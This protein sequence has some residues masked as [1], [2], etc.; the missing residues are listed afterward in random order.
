MADQQ[1]RLVFGDDGSA[2]ADLVWLWINNH[3]WPGWRISVV[4][5]RPPEGVVA[6]EG[7][8]RPHPWEPPV[9]R[10]LFEHADAAAV[11]YLTASA[12]P[13]V[14]L[15][16]LDASL[17]A[18]GPRGTGLL[19]AMNIGSTAEWLVHGHRPVVIVRSA[20]PTRRVLACVDGSPDAQRAVDAIADLPWIDDCDVT[21]LGV[22][23]GL[24]DP[25]VGLQRAEQTLTDRAKSVEVKEAA[26]IRATFTMDVKSVILDLIDEM[27]PDLAVLGTRGRGGVQRLLLGSTAGTVARYARCSVL[28]AGVPGDD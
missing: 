4:T 18:I 23:D 27:K 20:R 16:S 8:A 19:K 15:G 3:R 5:A 1:P 25:G 26:A 14:V 22:S 6:V 11:E 28:V 10:L 13:R 17:L 12:D 21:L 9:P 2:A 24:S 7:D